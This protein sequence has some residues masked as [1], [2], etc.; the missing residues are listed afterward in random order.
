MTIQLI[1]L[2]FVQIHIW[3]EIGSNLVISERLGNKFYFCVAL[4]FSIGQKKGR[5]Y[6]VKI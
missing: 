2:E 5:Y 4:D 3:Q 1:N 6:W